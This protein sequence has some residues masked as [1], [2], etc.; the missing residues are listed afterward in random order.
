MNLKSVRNSL[1]DARKQIP[2][3]LPGI[4][5]VKFPQNWIVPIDNVLSL[6]DFALEFLRQTEIIVSIKFYVSYLTIDN[7]TISHRH[8]YKEFNNQNNKFC[9]NRNWDIFVDH[10]V[11]ANWNGMPPW[12][13][14][15]MFFPESGPPS[16]P[17]PARPK[18]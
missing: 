17:A 1:E 5:F 10:P 18:A 2:K 15:I 16:A 13:T 6:H 3:E 9:P 14:R 11:P 12:W 4:V 8:A 7:E